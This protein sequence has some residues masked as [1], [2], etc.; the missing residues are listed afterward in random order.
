MSYLTVNGGK[1][2]DGELT[3][4]G[5]KNSVLPLLA[6]T[7]LCNGRSILHNCPDLSD[8]RAS[9]DI[10]ECLG[11]KC[12]REGKTVIID[13]RNV[14]GSEIPE[15]LMH[16]MRS[17]IVFMGA[18]AAR[19]GRAVMGLPGGCELGPRPI[20]IHIDALKRLGADIKCEAGVLSC[21][22]PRLVGSADIT[23]R[24][25]SVGATENILLASSVG[26]GT[27]I[28]RN[29]AKEPEIVD[30]ALFLNKAGA[31]IAGAGSDT[32]YIYGVRALSGVEHNVMPD[33][34]IAATCLF[35][36]AACGGHIKLNNIVIEHIS[37]II[38]ILKDCGCDILIERNALIL[39]APLRVSNIDT[40]STQPYPGF[41]TDAGPSLVAMS[42]VAKGTGVFIENIFD[43]RFRYIDELKRLGA[44]IKTVGRVA[45]ISGVK[46]LT[47]A[48]VT[49]YDL[50]GGAALTAAAIS[51]KGSSEIFGTEFIDRG[52]DKIE[53]IFG[54]LGADITRH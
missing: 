27:T 48:E 22:L 16:K 49:A 50:R 4:H 35:G 30:L 34:I 40:V 13:S 10:L 32:V 28:I 17:S 23:L 5:A 15:C 6:A 36:A 11:C 26:K 46:G 37:P 2:L 53:E 20:D 24:F 44:N 47:G 41:P 39:K 19:C 21:E 3:I 29:A 38:S 12:E 1:K 42:A 14:N 33:R 31:R 51:A 7:Y 43:N 54:T 8:V 25:P 18:V 45:V 9:L 52:Y